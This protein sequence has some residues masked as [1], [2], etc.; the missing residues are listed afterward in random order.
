MPGPFV[1]IH[2]YKPATARRPGY[3]DSVHDH[4]YSF[5]SAVVRGGYVHR[6][7]DVVGQA[8]PVLQVER[9]LEAPHVYVLDADEVHS[10]TE[11]RDGTLSLVVQAPKRRGYSTEYVGVDGQPRRHYDFAS[12]AQG[13]EGPRERARAS[14]G[15]VRPRST[16]SEPL[17]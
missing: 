11:M 14:H 12:R 5:C 15:H 9:V 2:E 4:R 7:F 17:S 16:H 3:A 6:I 8:A 13:C 10:V 1:W